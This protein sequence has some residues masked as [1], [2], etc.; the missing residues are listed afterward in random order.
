[1]KVQ[2]ITIG[3]KEYSLNDIW[4]LCLKM[5]QDV[6]DSQ[7]I[8]SAK[9]AWL[10]ANGF[11][12]NNIWASCFFCEWD[13]QNRLSGESVCEHCPGKLV[14]PRFSCENPSYD[15]VNKPKKFEKKIR[16][17]DQKRKSK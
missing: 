5:W 11:N 6:K 8:G 13:I 17:L 3:D 4:K 2:R 15:W 14:S 1:M 10:R 9:N 16:A 7:S 12:P